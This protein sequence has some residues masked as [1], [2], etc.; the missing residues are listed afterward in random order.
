ML[1]W[2]GNAVVDVNGE[3]V[4]FNSLIQALLNFL[5]FIFDKYLPT[6]IK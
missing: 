5:S 4:S 1:T 6:E 3:E 2:N